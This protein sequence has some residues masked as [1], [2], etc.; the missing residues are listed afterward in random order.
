MDGNLLCHC[1]NP[2]IRHLLRLEL[3]LVHAM[4]CLLQ[5]TPGKYWEIYAKT[6]KIIPGIRLTN[7]YYQ[8]K[9]PTYP[10]AGTNTHFRI[11]RGT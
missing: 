1:H 7:R 11:R 5:P 3:A 8:A 9:G 4:G 2:L 10:F 6:V